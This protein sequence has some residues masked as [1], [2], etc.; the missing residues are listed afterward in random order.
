MI[1]AVSHSDFDAFDDIH[2]EAT[3]N[4]RKIK[5]MSSDSISI[6]I[7]WEFKKILLHRPFK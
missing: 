1:E 7:T 5:V 4:G 2:K 3:W 6:S